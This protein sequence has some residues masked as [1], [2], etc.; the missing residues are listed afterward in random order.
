[1]NGNLDRKFY[2]KIKKKEI[3]LLLNDKIAYR[4]LI[5]DLAIQEIMKDKRK[6]QFSIRI[7]PSRI[8]I[9]MFGK[10]IVEID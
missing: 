10:Q 6:K 9:V 7:N 8:S 1:M 2:S 5:D 4:E 3:E